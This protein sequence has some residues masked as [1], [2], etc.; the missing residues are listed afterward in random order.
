M[1]LGTIIYVIGAIATFAHGY[2]EYDENTKPDFTEE[3]L[4][5]IFPAICWPIVVPV[6]IVQRL[7]D[8]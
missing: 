5:L 3:V 7:L 6:M 4:P 8:K 2:S 1:E